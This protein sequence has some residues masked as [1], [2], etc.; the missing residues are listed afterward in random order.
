MKVTT[1]NLSR[2]HVVLVCCF[3]SL[4]GTDFLSYETS[5]NKRLKVCYSW[6][7]NILIWQQ[8]SQFRQEGLSGKI[9]PFN[10]NVTAFVP[11]HNGRG[12]VRAGK[13]SSVMRQVS[14]FLLHLMQR[15]PSNSH[16]N[17]QSKDKGVISLYEDIIGS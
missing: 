12:T 3:Q 14:Y 5:L 2:Q 15:L 17:Q 7:L 16:C 6:S 13:A 1:H 11:P 9:T 8:D 4:F 10:L